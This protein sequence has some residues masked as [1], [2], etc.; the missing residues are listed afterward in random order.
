[1]RFPRFAEKAREV[2]EGR[3]S[4]SSIEDYRELLCGDCPFYHQGE[5]EN[6][7]C[8]SFLLLKSWLEKGALDLE[9]LLDAL[10]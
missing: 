7:E 2:V 1:M 3:S 8:G 9:K 10:E 4:L 5:E 6:L